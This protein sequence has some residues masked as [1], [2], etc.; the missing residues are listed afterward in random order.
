MPSGIAVPVLYAGPQ[1]QFA[2]VDQINVSLPR[3]LAGAGLAGITLTV[4]GH[5]ANPVTLMIR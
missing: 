4:D 2:G 1:G 5:P 3:T